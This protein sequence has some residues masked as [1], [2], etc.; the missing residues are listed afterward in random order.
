[1]PVCSHTCA[2]VEYRHLWKSTLDHKRKRI[3]QV[4]LHFFNA[5]F[6]GLLVVVVDSF[7]GIEPTL[8]QEHWI[9]RGTLHPQRE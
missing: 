6:P 5:Y 1:M 9:V 3:F 2:T 8:K 4:I 7:A